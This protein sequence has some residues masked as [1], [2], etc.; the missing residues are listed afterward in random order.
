LAGIGLVLAA[1]MKLSA[2][3][4][5]GVLILAFYAP[6]I[7]TAARRDLIAVAA[8]GAIAA[9]PYLGNLIAGGELLWLPP[10]A[11]FGIP[12]GEVYPPLG[13]AAF[14]RLFFNEMLAHWGAFDL[15]DPIEIAGLVAVAAV[16]ALSIGRSR[17]ARAAA[18][19]LVATLAV[20]FA[21]HYLKQTRFG[22]WAGSAGTWPR[23]YLPIWPAVAVGGAVA[24]G[25]IR[26]ERVRNIVA[27]GLLVLLAWGFPSLAAVRHLHA[28]H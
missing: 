26:R 17:L 16:F 21:F 22:I 14:A 3:L 5:L 12:P 7:R 1:W 25:N 18:V 8:C 28:V 23:Y 20:H 27:A 13:P 2:A 10:A 9:L 11:D 19:A 6:A 15:S 24:I 4:L